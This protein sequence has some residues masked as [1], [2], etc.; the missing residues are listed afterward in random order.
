MVAAIEAALAA[1]EVD[2]RRVVEQV[3]DWTWKA[4][5]PVPPDLLRTFAAM[6]YTDPAFSELSDQYDR[7]ERQALA[8]VVAIGCRIQLR[9][10]L[11]GQTLFFFCT[12]Q[13]SCIESGKAIV[14]PRYLKPHQLYQLFFNRF[15]LPVP[16]HTLAARA[17]SQPVVIGKFQTFLANIIDIGKADNMRGHLACGIKTPVFFLQVDT[18]KI[19]RFDPGRDFRV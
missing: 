2:L 15:T 1:G 14:E 7:Y 11:L 5:H 3:V 9:D 18:M 17:S 13:K 8:R 16:D 4:L 6:A 12:R 10:F 19:K